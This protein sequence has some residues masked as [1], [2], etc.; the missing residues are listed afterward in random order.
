MD[1]KN[2]T[3]SDIFGI[4]M[5]GRQV[6]MDRLQQLEAGEAPIPEVAKHR[7]GAWHPEDLIDPPPVQDTA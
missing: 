3:E 5:L 1:K 4:W 2:L 7:R 6:P